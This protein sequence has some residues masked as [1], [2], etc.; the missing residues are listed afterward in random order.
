MTEFP[1]ELNIEHK[2]NT[3]EQP[4]DACFACS[5]YAYSFSFSWPIISESRQA[6]NLIFSVISMEQITTPANIRRQTAIDCWGVA[7]W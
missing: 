3:S 2:I 4:I 1:K 6:S 7:V 5:A